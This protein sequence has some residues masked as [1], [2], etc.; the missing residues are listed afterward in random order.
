MGDSGHVSTNERRRQMALTKMTTD[1]RVE[2]VEEGRALA[3]RL[4]K[5]AAEVDALIVALT[6][7]SK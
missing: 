5:E 7:G 6:E 4:R 3:A 2:F 1:E